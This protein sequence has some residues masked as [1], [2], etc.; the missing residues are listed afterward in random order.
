M[1]V[2]GRRGTGNG[3]ILSSLCELSR[4]GLLKSALVVSRHAESA[5]DVLLAAKVIN[6]TL[7]TELPVEHYS[8]GDDGP[9]ALR[10]IISKCDAAILSLPDHLHSIF[11]A[12]LLSMKIPTLIVKPLAPN[13]AEAD[14]LLRAQRESGTYAAVEFHKR[15]DETNLTAKRL[16]ASGSLGDLL[17]CVV[18]YSQRR[19]IPKKT[20]FSWASRSNILQYLGVHYI[21]LFY[22][23]TGFRPVRV[24]AIGTYG[25]LKECGIDTWDSIHATII[26]KSRNGKDCIQ[27]ISCNWIDPEG[28]SA[29]SD[30]KYCLVGTKG[31][32]DIDQKHR[33]M[34]LIAESGGVQ[35]LNPYFSEYLPSPDGVMHFKGYAHDSISCFIADVHNIKSGKRKISD[36]EGRR[37]TLQGA[38]ISTA[39]L[40]YAYRSLQKQG[41]WETIACTETL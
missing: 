24:S 9:D 23:L 30:Q 32:L 6:E 26:W 36:M 5:E 16:I 15:W 13:L 12:Y 31:R 29:L 33:G 39:V 14:I 8:I 37:P 3:T 22:F 27:Q 41:A 34:E 1:Y 20:F 21:D 19:S 18:E 17:Y 38:L 11:G 2:T 25:N 28:T 35:S 4:T 10:G 7:Q 40:D